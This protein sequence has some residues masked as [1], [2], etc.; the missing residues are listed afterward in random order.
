VTPEPPES[1]AL[2]RIVTAAEIIA[3]AA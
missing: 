2:R 1:F 3:A